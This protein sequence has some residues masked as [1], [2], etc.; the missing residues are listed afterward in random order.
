GARPMGVRTADRMAISRMVWSSIPKRLALL[1]HVLDAIAGLR[2]PAQREEPFALEVEDVLF[3][4]R[5]AGRHRA[6]RKRAGEV[7]GDDGVVRGDLVR[8]KQVDE[9][10]LQRCLPALAHDPDAAGW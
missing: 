3:A 10:L 1:Q 6:A 7:A 4:H 2:F 8:A 9:R 5:R